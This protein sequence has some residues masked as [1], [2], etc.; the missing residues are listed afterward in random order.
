MNTDI[1]VWDILIPDTL[2]SHLV[3]KLFLKAINL[4]KFTCIGKQCDRFLV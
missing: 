1:C 2:Y 3:F 4:V